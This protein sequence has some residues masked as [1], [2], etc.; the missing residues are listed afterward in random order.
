MS[1]VSRNMRMNL[2]LLIS[3]YELGHRSH[4]TRSTFSSSSGGKGEGGTE[5]LRL[6]RLPVVP[7]RDDVPLEREDCDCIGVVL[8]NK[9]QIR[10][11]KRQESNKKER[12]S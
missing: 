1:P 4:Q 2:E 12:Q 3:P 7:S 10:Q 5:S 8:S 11:R 6:E 9:M